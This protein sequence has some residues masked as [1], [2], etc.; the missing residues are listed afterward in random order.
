MAN[1]EHLEV[2]K[3]GREAV[4]QWRSANRDIAPDLRGADLREIDMY[5]MN[6]MGANFEHANLSGANLNGAYLNWANFRGA[7]LEGANM[8]AALLR[9]A[10]LS[11]AN[12]RGARLDY[13]D[14]TGA[15]CNEVDFREASLFATFRGT[16][17][18]QSDLRGANLRA[19]DL[20]D[21]KVLGVQFDNNMQCRGVCA[22]NCT[23]SQRFVRHVLD[24]DYIE[25]TKEKYPKRYKFWKWT[26]DC[27]RSWERW[28]M[29]SVCIAVVFGTIYMC[30]L[31]WDNL[32]DV[33]KNVLPHLNF[34][35][36]EM[37]VSFFT[38]Y[39]FSIVTFTTL[40]FGDITPLNLAG[41][42]WLTLEVVFGYI[43]LG[44]L[45]T[46]FATKMVR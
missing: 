41:Q 10:L 20:A 39:Y 37:D 25:E 27:G 8:T 40:G 33:L 29:L 18:I 1:I 13:A 36:S 14:L 22:Q 6:L 19:T 16:S 30:S 45:I 43:M 42:V 35:V 38:P 46:L 32:P 34:N 24:L 15:I 17:L 4:Q 9:E 5:K 28:A 44:G 11:K 3:Q 7:N 2:I 31:W 21:T 26:S 23:G 12:L